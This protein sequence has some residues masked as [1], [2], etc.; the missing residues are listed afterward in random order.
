MPDASIH[1]GGGTGL[2]LNVGAVSQYRLPVLPLTL[3]GNIRYEIIGVGKTNIGNTGVLDV[4]AMFPIIPGRKKTGRVKIT[5]SYSESSRY[6]HEEYF[7]V[8]GR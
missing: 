2:G 3:R 8:D 6:I 5:T 1:L 7:V 4:G